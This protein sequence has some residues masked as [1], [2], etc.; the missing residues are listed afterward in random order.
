MAF[1]NTWAKWEE[2]FLKYEVGQLIDL[3]TMATT[4]ESTNAKELTNLANV[5]PTVLRRLNSL[6]MD[7]VGEVVDHILSNLP[8][9][10]MGKA[11]RN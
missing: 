8:R 5:T 4:S 6:S 10:F 11:P 2:V 3:D 1:D 7:Q 9:I